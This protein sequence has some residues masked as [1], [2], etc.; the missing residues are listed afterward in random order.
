MKKY[1]LS[2]IFIPFAFAALSQE[3]TDVF[4]STDI[5]LSGEIINK[6]DGEFVPYVHIINLSTNQ[7]TTS[8][9][10]GK[11]NISI[12]KEDTLMF[13]SVGFD[14]YKLTFSDHEIDSDSYFI[15]ILLDQSSYELSPVN[16]FA[17][18]D[19]AGFKQ[20]ILN[21]KLP[22]ASNPKILVPGSYGGPLTSRDL[23]GGFSLG[24]PIS[25][26]VNIFSKEAKEL[27]KYEKVKKDYPRQKTINEKYNMEVVEEITGLKDE[28]L[29]KFM[30][31][32]KISDDYILTA[33][34]YEIV[35]AVHN[36]YKEFLS[37]DN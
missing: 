33:N 11:F 32:C 20:D 31:F 34:D 13:S 7:G 4:E 25:S 19:E 23:N 14:K 35:V 30:L 3:L 17:F 37:S 22:E 6:E 2:I 28:D 36:C 15:R 21:M 9:L 29:N 24:S 8:D 16:I 5:N 27:R 26:V 12:S 1:L 18:K 10:E